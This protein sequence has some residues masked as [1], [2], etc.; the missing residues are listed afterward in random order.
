M[1]HAVTAPDPVRAPARPGPNRALN[2]LRAVAAVLVVVYHL[3]QLLFVDAADAGDGLSTRLLYA[4]TNMGPAAVVVFFVLSGYWVGGSVFSGFRR[5]R[6]RWASY[7]TARL[8]RL[9]IVLIPAVALTTILDRV[10]LA[11]LSGTSIYL[12][13]PAYHHTV[14][15]D[16]LAGRLT[17]GTALGNVFFLQT[18]A[19]PTYGT[20]ASLWS[21]AYE[22]VF[23]AVLPLALYAWRGRG[24]IGKRALSLVLLLG[25]CA[26]AGPAVLKYLPVWLMGAVAALYREPVRTW[27]QARSARWLGWSRA[28]ASAGLTAG[29]WLAQASY[30]SVN[31]LLLAAATTVLLVLLVE[32]VGWTGVPG[33]VLG[34]LSDYADSSYSL[35]AI[36]LPVAA[37]TAA[38]LTPHVAA[39]WA[40]TATHWL[41]LAGICAVL[42][43]IGW[44]FAHA[45]ERHTDR[46]RRIADTLIASV[47]SRTRT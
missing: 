42:T 30:S 24:G 16:G 23:Y 39:R 20:N 25:L 38:L 5:D 34:G 8:S 6:F 10:G 15:A 29:L 40:P 35:Y 9:W 14:P 17:A 27:L 1:T 36:H 31:V 22:A 19:V 7:A 47:A 11:L 13:D 32:D 18:M 33:R 45:T 43:A 26:L 4:V 3:R 44:A 41:A 2:A 12:G 37:M 28:G 21:L 46:V